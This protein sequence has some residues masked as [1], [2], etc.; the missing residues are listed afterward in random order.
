MGHVYAYIPVQIRRNTLCEN[1]IPQ[2]YECFCERS[3][4]AADQALNGTMLF[5]LQ[6]CLRLGFLCKALRAWLWAWLLL[7]VIGGL[8]V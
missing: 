7:G 5:W 4:W 2:L 3:G 1:K 8:G 6:I